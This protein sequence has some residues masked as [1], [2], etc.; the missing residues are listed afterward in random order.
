MLTREQM[1]PAV[2]K[3]MALLD[4]KQPG[5]MHFINLASLDLGNSVSCVLGQIYGTYGEGLD[6]VFGSDSDVFDVQYQDHGFVLH[7]DGMGGI[8]T[9]VEYDHLTSV[10][11][12]QIEYWV[13]EQ[14]RIGN[15]TP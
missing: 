10:W 14:D 3:G 5:W 13:A 1:M 12:D 2:E 11:H 4:E 6:H 15:R 9:G 7:E 8:E